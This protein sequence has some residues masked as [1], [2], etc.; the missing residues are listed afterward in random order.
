MTNFD[1]QKIF[2]SINAKLN[3]AEELTRI[4]DSN[5]SAKLKQAA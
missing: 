4:I 5:L 3:R 2:A 1:I